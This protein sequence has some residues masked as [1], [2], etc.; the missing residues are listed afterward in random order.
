MDPVI[1]AILALLVTIN[2]ARNSRIDEESK[3]ATDALMAIEDA[4][5]KTLK[6]E[7]EK[8]ATGQRSKKLEI[9]V[10]TA[11]KKVS[12]LVYGYSPELARRIE[13]KGSY[14]YEPERWTQKEIEDAGIG[15]ERIRE[16]TS[17]LLK[18]RIRRR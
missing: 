3:D 18:P 12:R 1:V 4:T 13:D 10:A 15:L 6:Y 2:N 5:E 7:A 16:E 14:W 9:E 17:R 8:E 11:W